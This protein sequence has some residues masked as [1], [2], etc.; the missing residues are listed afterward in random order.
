MVSSRHTWHTIRHRWRRHRQRCPWKNHHRAGTLSGTMCASSNCFAPMAT[1]CAAPR[2]KSRMVCSDARW[3]RSH[4]PDHSRYLSA[5][6]NRQPLDGHGKPSAFAI[7][8]QV[9]RSLPHPTGTT[10]TPL[11]GSCAAKGPA[12]GRRPVQPRQPCTG[13][14]DERPD[15]PKRRLSVPMTPPI[16]L[17]NPLSLRAFNQFYFHRH[18]ARS[19]MPLRTTS[20]SSI[21]W[22]AF[23]AWNR[24]YG[25]S[26]VLAIS[27]CSAARGR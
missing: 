12:L 11:R 9:L 26:R 13:T 3:P 4:R 19:Y 8:P 18:A 10:N 20:P 6:P 27:M 22:T 1:E 17:I 24:I 21:R 23:G 7:C 2:M 25:P 15:A 5:A 14:T 16:S